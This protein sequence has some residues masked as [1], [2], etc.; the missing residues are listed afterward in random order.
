M[1][2]IQ[3]PKVEYFDVRTDKIE[4]KKKSLIDVIEV[5]CLEIAQV[6]VERRKTSFQILSD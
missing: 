1:L 6:E 5:P 4:I 2:K 3:R